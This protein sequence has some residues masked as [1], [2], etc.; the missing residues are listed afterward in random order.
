MPPQR[1][2]RFNVL[3]LKK[4]SKGWRNCKEIPRWT[5]I[6]RIKGKIMVRIDQYACCY[7]Y[8]VIN[9]YIEGGGSRSTV[10]PSWTAGEQVHEIDPVAI[11]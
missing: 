7:L 4:S 10:A 1:F 6:I 11:L 5:G 9:L 8:K 3:H 2:F